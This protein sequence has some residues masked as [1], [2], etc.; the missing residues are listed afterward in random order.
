MHDQLEK[1]EKALALYPRIAFFYLLS[2]AITVLPFFVSLSLTFWPKLILR[3]VCCLILSFFLCGTERLYRA[4]ALTDSFGA[5]AELSLHFKSIMRCTLRRYLRVMP[6]FI[7][8]FIPAALLYYSVF[9]NTSDLKAMRLLKTIGDPVKGLISTSS[10][11]PSYDFG[12]A[13]LIIL[14]FVFLMI[15]AIRWHRDVPLDYGIKNLSAFH[16]QH[17]K[18]W[19]KMTCFNL[20]ISLPPFMLSCWLLFHSLME[21]TGNSRQGL[22][23]TLLNMSTQFGTMFQKNEIILYLLL[24]LIFIYLPCWCVRK[25][26]ITKECLEDQQY[27]S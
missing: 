17:Q 24:I 16:R 21:L 14:A 12:C 7:L 22:F 11:G 6:F 13:V 5:K 25:Y 26:C 2:R 20:L 8:F 15:T 18:S 23:S 4:K 9:D 10:R 27:A 3:C 19:R 1:V